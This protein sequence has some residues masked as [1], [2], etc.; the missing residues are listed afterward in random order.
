MSGLQLST[1]LDGWLSVSDPAGPALGYVRPGPDGELGLLREARAIEQI[2]VECG[3]DLGGLVSD[4]GSSEPADSSSPG[5]C[6][7]LERIVAGEASALVVARLDS[8]AD[9]AA[10][11]GAMM[12]WFNRTGARFIA[13]DIGLDTATPSGRLAANAL[14]AAGQ[15]ERRKL[16]ERTRQG[17]EAAREKGARPGRP[18]VA[19]RPELRARIRAL[20][21]QGCTLQ[22]IS[23]MLNAEGVSTLRGGAEWRPSSVQSAAGYKRPSRGPLLNGLPA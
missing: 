19:D 20:R 15:L 9:S 2:C 23:D 18:A 10:G 16:Q 1:H 8:L 17:L 12:E 14:S 5:L 22:A 21:A 7:A 3:L 4:E 13:A 6:Q 11:V